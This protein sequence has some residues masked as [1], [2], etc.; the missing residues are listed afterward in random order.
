MAQY[1]RFD[2]DRYMINCEE[3]REGT[4]TDSQRMKH[5]LDSQNRQQTTKA[6]MNEGECRTNRGRGETQRRTYKMR[7][8][9]QSTYTA[10][11]TVLAVHWSDL[12]TG[13]VA[14]ASDRYA[15]FV[16][17]PLNISFFLLNSLCN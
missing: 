12:A 15:I 1:A 7:R 3:H 13:V 5:K 4:G 17:L 6:E 11:S 8:T 2:G 14:L 16:S 9:L 10:D